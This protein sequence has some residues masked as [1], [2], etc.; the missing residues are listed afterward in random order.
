MRY[1]DATVD[2][3]EK[4][5]LEALYGIPSY[6]YRWGYRITSYQCVVVYYAGGG[7]CVAYIFAE[8]MTG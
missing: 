4:M 8:M 3:A 6:Q 1:K 2:N 7:V 5:D